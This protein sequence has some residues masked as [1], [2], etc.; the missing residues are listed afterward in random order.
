ME[1]PLD[2]RAFLKKAVAMVKRAA[3]HAIPLYLG[4]SSE[5]HS[6]L[7]KYRDKTTRRAKI[8]MLRNSRQHLEGMPYS[9]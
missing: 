9:P 7:F 3:K 1:L 5:A 8:P 2:L 6:F 4:W